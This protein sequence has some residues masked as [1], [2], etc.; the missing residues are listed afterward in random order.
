MSGLEYWGNGY[1]Y[2]A[3]GNLKQ[4]NVTKCE[5]ESLSAAV[6]PN[7]QLQGY[8]YDAAGNM[9]RDNKGTPYVYDAENR[10]SS[11]SGFN[12]VYDADGNRVQKVNANT[13]PA[14]G[15]LYWYMSAG[16]VG[17]SD[18]SGTLQSEYVFFNGERAARKDFPGNAVSY[19]F[20]DHLKTASVITDAVGNI[21]S[22]SD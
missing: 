19:Y 12:Y 5:A 13:N 18:L 16:I 21:K 10:I 2:D 17:E 6:N 22:E 1:V 14:T 3:W 11:T 15:T 9:M 8:D 7:N 20:S 4:K